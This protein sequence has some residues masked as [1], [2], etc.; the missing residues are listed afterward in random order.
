MSSTGSSTSTG[1][2]LTSDDFKHKSC[3]PLPQDWQDCLADDHIFRTKLSEIQKE[4]IA[5]MKDREENP[6]HGQLGGLVIS[7]LGTGKTLTVL[8]YLLLR[9]LMLN[10]NEKTMIVAP[11]SVL[12]T[13]M[14]QIEEHFQPKQLSVLLFHGNNRLIDLDGVKEENGGWFPDLFITSYGTLKNTS[15]YFFENIVHRIV[16]DEAHHI[17]NCSTKTSSR[18][19]KLRTFPTF[20]WCLTAT[21]IWNDLND[22]W[23]L[24]HFL[25]AWPLEDRLSWRHEILNE[26]TVQRQISKLSEFLKPITLRRTKAEICLPEKIEDVVYVQMEEKEKLFYESLYDNTRRKIETLLNLERSLRHSSWAQAIRKR[27]NLSMFAIFLRL[28]QACVHPQLVLDAFE[29]ITK[30]VPGGEIETTEN[31]PPSSLNEKAVQRLLEMMTSKKEEDCSVCLDAVADHCFHPCGHVF[32]ETCISILLAMRDNV[33]CPICRC[34]VTNYQKNDSV[35][36]MEEIEEEEEKADTKTVSTPTA[37][38]KGLGTKMEWILNDMQVALEE[39]RHMK[40]LI[41][42]Q[43]TSALDIFQLRLKQDRGIETYQ[44]HG[45]MTLKKRAQI[46]K[47]FL[48]KEEPSV[49]FVSLMAGG[50]G[51]NLQRASRAYFLEPWW[52]A[53]RQEQGGNR[54]HRIGQQRDVKIVHLLYQ[55]SVEERVFKIQHSK[56]MLQSNILGVSG[57][58]AAN[59]RFIFNL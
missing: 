50:E 55:D 29:K 39:D 32:C 36:P 43:W 6:Y 45:R 54:V 47:D 23:P 33:R 38:W 5:F 15:D 24:F 52:T 16:L 22:L 19:L 51:L 37:F 48:E 12:H 53:A 3:P 11:A 25:K 9:K 30:G 7:E 46:Q 41:F 40:F 1:T 56:R 35:A 58:A 26:I 34:R 44:L 27:M 14:H 20:K 28:R 42:S 49:L 10:R 59:I 21:P 17:R 18:V 8:A 4:S 31:E 2:L 57:A 13:W